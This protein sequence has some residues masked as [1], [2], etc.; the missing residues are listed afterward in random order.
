MHLCN[1]SNVICSKLLVCWHYSHGLSRQWWFFGA[2]IPK[3]VGK[4]PHKDL[5][6]YIHQPQS[7]HVEQQAVCQPA[8]QQNCLLKA[9]LTIESNTGAYYGCGLW[10]TCSQYDSLGEY[11]SLHLRFL[12]ICSISAVKYNENIATQIVVALKP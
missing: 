3:C 7:I 5:S 9:S 4:Q 6:H 10:Q 8:K 2:N 12:A 1:A 11:C